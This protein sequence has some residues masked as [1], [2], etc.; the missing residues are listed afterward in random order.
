MELEE[1]FDPED[2]KLFIGAD[3]IPGG[4]IPKKELAGRSLTGGELETLIQLGQDDESQVSIAPSYDFHSRLYGKDGYWML[5]DKPKAGSKDDPIVPG[6]TFHA[7]KLAISLMMNPPDT[8]FAHPFIDETVGMLKRGSSDPESHDFNSLTAW[9]SKDRFVEMRIPWM[10]LGFGDP[11]S[12]Q[13]VDYSPLKN[14]R[15]FS[16][17]TTEGIKLAP[18][19]AK[20]SELDGSADPA[21]DTREIDLGKIQPYTWELWETPVYS[22]RLKQSYYDMQEI[23]TRLP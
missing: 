1:A 18:W 10:L 12:L 8:R 3:T 7:W 5:P 9:Q 15:E 16:T 4:D 22:E 6:G 19:I 14:K 20:R 17:V 2:S 13:V 23:F 21:A 11:S